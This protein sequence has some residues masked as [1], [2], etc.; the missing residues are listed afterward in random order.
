MITVESHLGRLDDHSPP[1]EHRSVGGRLCKALFSSRT[2]LI[3][4]FVVTAVAVLA[5]GRSGLTLPLLLPGIVNA[6]VDDVVTVVAFFVVLCRVGVVL[7]VGVCEPSS[8]A[9]LTKVRT[10]SSTR[11]SRNTLMPS[12][13]PSETRENLARF[14][15]QTGILQ[16]RSHLSANK[17]TLIPSSKSS[18]HRHLLH[19]QH[20]HILLL[21]RDCDCQSQQSSVPKDL[22]DQLHTTLAHFV[23]RF[24]LGYLLKVRQDVFERLASK[25]RGRVHIGCMKDGG[26]VF[27]RDGFQHPLLTHGHE[28]WNRKQIGGFKQFHGGFERDPDLVCVQ[29]FKDGK[30]DR[31][32]D[33]F[34]VHLGQS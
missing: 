28:A 4:A 31:V 3:D 21:L 2:R 30:K 9:W 25:G 29:V 23:E 11:Q 20:Q 7:C 1:F 16:I 14:N 8:F 15:R 5:V 6:D 12:V 24:R 22:K 27:D 26:S 10:V 33:L 17:L 32:A 13:H 18:L 19:H 34:D